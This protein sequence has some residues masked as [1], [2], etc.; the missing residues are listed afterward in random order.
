MPL[1]LAVI[2]FESVVESLVAA[3]SDDLPR[4]VK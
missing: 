4:G 1:E 2:V 3:L